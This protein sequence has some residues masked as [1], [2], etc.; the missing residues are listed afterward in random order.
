MPGTTERSS[1]RLSAVYETPSGLKDFAHTI[2]TPQ[3]KNEGSVE[4][5]AKSKYLSELR[6][7]TKNLQEDINKFLTEKMEEDKKAASQNSL[8]DV[9]K[10]K[11]KDELEEENYGEENGEEET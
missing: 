5:E 6:A 7:S 1:A 4:T 3:V 10:Q 11:S 2:P 9:S 8:D